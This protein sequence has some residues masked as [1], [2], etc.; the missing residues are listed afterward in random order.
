MAEAS[1]HL[2]ECGTFNMVI[3]VTLAGVIA[4]TQYLAM[5]KSSQ[6][7]VGVQ[8]ITLEQRTSLELTDILVD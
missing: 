1:R 5:T 2:L 3:A 7:G 8:E 6:H 4:V